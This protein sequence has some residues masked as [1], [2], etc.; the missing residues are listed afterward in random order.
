MLRRMS[1][2]CIFLAS[3]GVMLVTNIVL[4]WFAICYVSL[5][6]SIRKAWI[7]HKL[8][9]RSWYKPLR[10]FRTILIF[11]TVAKSA[12]VK[13]P[14]QIP[15]PSNLLTDF[16][17]FHCDN[18]RAQSLKL[19]YFDV[20]R[21]HSPLHPNAVVIDPL[22]PA[23]PLIY[24]CYIFFNCFTANTIDLIFNARNCFLVGNRN[25]MN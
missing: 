13:T 15:H 1:Y 3:R 22:L 2:I 18:L 20:Q 14:L 25:A 19:Q 17:P 5:M 8:C 12:T 21:S 23:P 4:D 24:S 6:M 9:M 10:T 7:N 11:R 16:Q